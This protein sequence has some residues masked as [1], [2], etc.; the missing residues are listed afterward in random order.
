MVMYISGQTLTLRKAMTSYLI[1]FIDEE[2]GC[3]DY[4]TLQNWEKCNVVI[5]KYVK[6]V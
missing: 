1:T 5:G 2:T 6:N 3:L 4:P